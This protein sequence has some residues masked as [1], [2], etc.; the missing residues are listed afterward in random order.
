MKPYN[1]CILLTLIL[2]GCQDG[3][4]SC[5]VRLNMMYGDYLFI[6][7]EMLNADEIRNN[8]KDIF[9]RTNILYKQVR[10]LSEEYY[11]NNDPPWPRFKNSFVELCK[12]IDDLSNIVR[13]VYIHLEADPRMDKKYGIIF[14]E[15]LDGLDGVIQNIEGSLEVI[16]PA[17]RLS[18]RQIIATITCVRREPMGSEVRQDKLVH[19]R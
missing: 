15:S 2:I 9:M 1:A 16:H 12:G 17:L 5:K 13:I 3:R 11:S 18:C 8:I 14:N 19:P 6:K 7:G 10:K 4:R